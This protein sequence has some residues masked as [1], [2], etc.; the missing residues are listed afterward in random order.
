MTALSG[1]QEHTHTSGNGLVVRPPGNVSPAAEGA[2]RAMLEARSVALV[3]ASAR[4]GTFGRRMLEE[5]GKSGRAATGPPG[6]PEVRRAR[7][8]PVLPVAGRSAGSAGAGA[9]R[10]A[11]RGPGGAA[12]PRRH[13]RQPVRGHLR[14][15]A[16]GQPARRHRPQPACPAGRHCAQLRHG[17]VRG[18]LHGLCQRQPRTARARLYRDRSASGWSG[19]AGHAFRVGVLRVA[20]R[21]SRL[22]LHAG[23]LVGAGTGDRGACLP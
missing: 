16:R 20:A 5:V 2:V 8:P 13:G 7:R 22:R 4:P 14:E 9:A 18:W 23:G 12:H 15:R 21:P 10:G 11:R 1:E 17:A 6:Q 3:G 19:G